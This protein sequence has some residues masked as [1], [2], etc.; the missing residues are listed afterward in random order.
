MPTIILSYR[1]DNK[2]NLIALCVYN[3]AYT[4]LHDGEVWSI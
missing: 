3:G 1:V 2:D 4:F